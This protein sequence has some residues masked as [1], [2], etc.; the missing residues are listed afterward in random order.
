MK[1]IIGNKIKKDGKINKINIIIE[2]DDP[3]MIE[4]ILKKNSIRLYTEY[5]MS[6][7]KKVIKRAIEVANI[8]TTGNLVHKLPNLKSILNVGK[9]IL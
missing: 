1:A 2:I 4:E 5:E 9:R 7:A 6:T 3:E 8:I